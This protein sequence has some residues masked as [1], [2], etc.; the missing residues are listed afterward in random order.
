MIIS[1]NFG[2]GTTSPGRALEVSGSINGTQLNISGP[3]NLAYGSGNVGIG[4]TSPIEKLVISGNMSVHNI[5][6]RTPSGV[7]GLIFHNGS[8]ICIVS[9]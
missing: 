7:G 1:G 2:I 3:T 6:I 4:T 9:C 5:S 8:G